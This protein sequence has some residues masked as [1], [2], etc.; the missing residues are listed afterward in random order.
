MFVPLMKMSR[1]LMYPIIQD[2]TTIIIYVGS[3]KLSVLADIYMHAIIS[4]QI[5]D[6]NLSR[7]ITNYYN[8]HV[9]SNDYAIINT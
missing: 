5:I 3:V 1:I 6:K 7:Y 4:Y 2:Y 9:H 8:I